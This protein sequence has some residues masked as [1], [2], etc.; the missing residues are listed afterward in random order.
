MKAK[1]IAKQ[2]AMQESRRY[3]ARMQARTYLFWPISVEHEEHPA[4]NTEPVL[5]KLRQAIPRPR[6]FQGEGPVDVYVDLTYPFTEAVPE[7][8]RTRNFQANTIEDVCREVRS[9]YE[10]IYAEDERLG[11]PV[12]NPNSPL[13]NRGLG[14]WVWG[15]DIGDLV[16]EIIDWNWV[17]PDHVHADIMIGS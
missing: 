6:S 4:N 12:K 9:I 7:D 14:P 8:V 13:I 16:I 5:S 15:H 17:N 11:G 10:G 1:R 2:R 3:R